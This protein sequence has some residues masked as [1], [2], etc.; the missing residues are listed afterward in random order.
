MKEES[1]IYFIKPT[2]PELRMPFFSEYLKRKKE[3]SVIEIDPEKLDQDLKKDLFSYIGKGGNKN[4]IDAIE[5]MLQN[6]KSIEM[7]MI[8]SHFFENEGQIREGIQVSDG[9]HRLFVFKKLGIKR[10]S[11]VVPTIQAEILSSIYGA[12]T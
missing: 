8:F 11:V 3:T 7:P 5:K 12:L 6:D 10:V 2:D 1:E 4:R 9:R